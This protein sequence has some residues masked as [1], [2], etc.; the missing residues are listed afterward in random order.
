M[1]NRLAIAAGMT[2]IGKHRRAATIAAFPIAADIPGV[3]V[4]INDI[5]ELRNNGR[6]GQPP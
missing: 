2:N 1:P 5:D 4:I 3:G 6:H